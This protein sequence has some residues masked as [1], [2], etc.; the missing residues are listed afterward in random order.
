MGACLRPLPHLLNQKLGTVP[1]QSQFWQAHRV[2]LLLAEVWEP[3]HQTTASL[4]YSHISICLLVNVPKQYFLTNNHLWSVYCMLVSV[5]LL[6]PGGKQ[7]E[8]GC[9]DKIW[10]KKEKKKKRQIWAGLR[11]VLFA[12]LRFVCLCWKLTNIVKTEVQLPKI[13]QCRRITGKWQKCQLEQALR[14]K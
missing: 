10:K 13:A 11:Q 8:V 2:T 4:Q 7:R 14:S 9:E 3:M 12:M 5:L 1:Q 6:A